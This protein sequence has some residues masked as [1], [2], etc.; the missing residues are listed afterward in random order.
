[1][2]LINNMKLCISLL[3]LLFF[4]VIKSTLSTPSQFLKPG[5]VAILSK[6]CKHSKK[7]TDFLVS[8]NVPHTEIYLEDDSEALN[9]VMKE[10]NGKV[11]WVYENGQFI[12]DGNAFITQYIKSNNNVNKQ[13]GLLSLDSIK[14][15]TLSDNGVDHSIIND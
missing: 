15:Y 12:G 8:N 6:K 3:V 2:K 13:I 10:K 7:L 14:Q 4:A 5:V 9:Y 1:M 11:P